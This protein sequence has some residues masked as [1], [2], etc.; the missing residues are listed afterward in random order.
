MP[1]GAALPGFWVLRSG[2]CYRRSNSTATRAI[3]CR[4]LGR[5]IQSFGKRRRNVA[6]DQRVVILTGLVCNNPRIGAV[7]RSKLVLSN[8][9]DP[10]LITEV[11]SL[12]GND[13]N[14]IDGGVAIHIS[15]R[16]PAS[17]QQCDI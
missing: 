7:R 8:I 11:E 4:E 9:G 10:G 5:A 13:I 12:N 15:S 14:C 17:C 2:R 6:E 1:P 3:T 16:Q